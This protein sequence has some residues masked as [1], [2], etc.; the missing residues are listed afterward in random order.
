VA[1]K[2]SDKSYSEHLS[3]NDSDLKTPRHDEIMMWLDDHCEMVVNA[4]VGN[5]W[6]EIESRSGYEKHHHKSI[7]EIKCILKPIPI[8]P[9]IR[10]LHKEWEFPVL[11]K[12]YHGNQPVGF[13]DLMAQIETYSLRIDFNKNS[14]QIYKRRSEYLFE[15]KTSIPSAGDLIRQIRFYQTFREGN[16]IVVSEDGRFKEV[17]L[18][19]GIGWICPSTE[20]VDTH[21]LQEGWNSW[22]MTG[23]V[24]APSLFSPSA[25]NREPEK[26]YD[27][28]FPL[29]SIPKRG[30]KIEDL[31][32]RDRI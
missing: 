14:W 25:P 16:Y 22:T 13:I 31:I 7:S 29:P 5:T 27:E 8:C 10:V 30:L 3:F 17:L 12:T 9:R 23:E 21:Q 26:A 18:R 20:G 2:S 24:I 1:T 6:E 4:L 19:N 32:P 15:V 11:K 28:P